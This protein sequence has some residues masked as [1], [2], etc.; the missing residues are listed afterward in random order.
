MEKEDL[1]KTKINFVKIVIARDKPSSQRL[2]KYRISNYL[3]D[4]IGRYKTIVPNSGGGYCTVSEVFR[5]NIGLFFGHQRRQDQS[6]V[7]WPSCEDVEI[8]LE[9]IKDKYEKEHPNDLIHTPSKNRR[10]G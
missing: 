9:D 3:N 1:T 5:D 2:Y 4:K 8:N 10:R 7:T 6:G